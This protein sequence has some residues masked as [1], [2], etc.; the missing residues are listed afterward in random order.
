M[1]LFQGGAIRSSSVDNLEVHGTTFQGNIAGEVRA[2]TSVLQFFFD[3]SAPISGGSKL[4]WGVSWST[5]GGLAKTF[6]NR[7]VRCV[8]IQR[9]TQ[10]S[11]D[12]IILT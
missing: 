8:Q 2:A 6:G 11:S 1:E 7:Y 3:F 12:H 4:Q 9:S 10:C 5:L